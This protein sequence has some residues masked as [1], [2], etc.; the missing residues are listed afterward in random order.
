MCSILT[1]VLEGHDFGIAGDM[2]VFNGMC[3]M[4]QSVQHVCQLVRKMKP[5]KFRCEDDIISRSYEEEGESFLLGR[6]TLKR[7]DQ[8]DF[9][10][11]KPPHLD[12]HAPSKL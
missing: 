6:S 4:V 10:D 12:P 8:V 1:R 7:G 9:D 11:P 2:I 3:D 5:V